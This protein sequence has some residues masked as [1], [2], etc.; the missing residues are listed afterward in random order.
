[1]GVCVG[2]GVGRRREASRARRQLAWG[3]GEQIPAQGW[4]L[5]P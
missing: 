3:L 2:V 4:G 5:G 1:M